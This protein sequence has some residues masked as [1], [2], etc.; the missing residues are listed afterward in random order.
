MPATNVDRGLLAGEHIVLALLKRGA[1]HGYEMAR[2]AREEGIG[3]VCALEQSALYAYLNNLEARGLVSWRE[4]RQGRRPPRKLY[5]L[6]ARG[7]EETDRWL[8]EPV[9]RMREVRREFLVKVH[10]LESVRSAEVVPLLQRQ[11]ATC[12]LYRERIAE[13][14]RGASGFA[15]LVALSKQSAAEATIAW[16]EAYA[17]EL[18]QGGTPGEPGLAR[19][20]GGADLAGNRS[21]R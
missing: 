13:E 21:L 5:A 10:L 14:L 17:D 15:R 4:Q 2:T 6:T 16:I 7:N 12:R 3:D 19:R 18:A 11:L 1:M 20:A 9:A 8:R